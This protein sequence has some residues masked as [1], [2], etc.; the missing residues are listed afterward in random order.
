VDQESIV[1][2]DPASPLGDPVTIKIEQ[3]RTRLELSQ[4]DPVAVKI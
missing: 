2:A 1:R 3:R 4:F